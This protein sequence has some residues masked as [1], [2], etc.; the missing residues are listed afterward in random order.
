MESALRNWI[1][2]SRPVRVSNKAARTKLVLSALRNKLSGGGGRRTVPTKIGRNFV[3]RYTLQ[4]HQ[5]I[6][7]NYMKTHKRLL[8]IHGTGSGKTL[9]AAHVAVDYMTSSSGNHR[10]VIFVTPAA[11]KNQFENSVS[12][13]LSGLPGIYFT[14]YDG[15]T[16]F[17]HK[18]YV[19]RHETFKSIVKNAMIIADEAH[20]ITEKTEKSRVFYDIFQNAN[21]VL[22]MTGTPIINGNPEDLIPYAKILNPSTASS[23]TAKTIKSNMQQIFRCKVSIYNVPMT[24]QN[25]P[26]LLPTER[27]KFNLSNANLSLVNQNKQ[28]KYEYTQWTGAAAERK[29]LKRG[30]WAYNRG[31]YSHKLFD[32]STI[33]PKFRKFLEIYRQNRPYKTIVFFKEYVTLDKFAEFLES[34]RIPYRRVTGKETNKSSIIR[35]NSVNSPM[36]YLLTSS[37]KEGLDFKGVRSVIFMDFPWVPSNYDQIVGRARRYLSHVNL[38][39]VNR[40]VKVYEL[41]Y[42]HP[43]KTTLNMRSMNLLNNK[44]SRISNMLRILESVSIERSNGG[45]PNNVNRNN[46]NNTN[47]RMRPRPNRVILNPNN[48]FAIDPVTGKRYHR[49]ALNI[50]SNTLIRVPK[51]NANLKTLFS[52]SSRKRLRQN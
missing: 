8:A 4:N 31:I 14:T 17:L 22:L 9:T 39:Q 7:R 21:K 24:S 23:I 29:R 37:A 47:N 28:R 1:T 5:K 2:R 30:G 42:T 19:S 25:F 11:V 38:P 13:V 46:N 18:L 50:P 16:G 34:E 27:F 20:N 45:C 10:L 41:A 36:V 35:Q 12:T 43:S 26:R 40:N 3:T 49:V 6:V 51:S 44:R 48:K 33:E 52:P 15:L 32:S